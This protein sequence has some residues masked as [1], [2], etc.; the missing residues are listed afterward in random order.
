MTLIRGSVAICAIGLTVA[1]ADAAAQSKAGEVLFANPPLLAATRTVSRDGGVPEEVY[2][3]LRVEM[4]RGHLKNPAT[5]SDDQVLLR[6]YR[7]AGS[8]SRDRGDALV[9]PTIEAVPGQTVRLTLDNR[10]TMHA[11]EPFYEENVGSCYTGRGPGGPNDP[12]C[13]NGTNMHTHGL[14]ISPSG[15]SDNVLLNINP[16]VTFQYEYNIPPDHPSGTF[17][18]HPHLHG[19]TALQVGSGMVGAL[20]VR[21]DRAPTLTETGDLDTLLAGFG[22]SLLV[23]QQIPYA[24]F[25]AEGNI[26]TNQNGTWRCDPGQDGIVQDYAKQLGGQAWKGSGRYTSINGTVIPNFQ[27]EEPGSVQRWRMIHAGVRDTINVEFRRITGTRASIAGVAADQHGDWIDRNCGGAPLPFHLVASDGLTMQRA[28]PKTNAVMQPGYRWDALTVFPE[29]G[30]YCMI[31]AQTRASASINDAA[32][33]PQLLATVTVGPGAPVSGDLD[34]YLIA[35]L[36]AA[37][38][39][40]PAAVRDRV[41]RELDDG[42]KLTSFVPHRSLLADPAE[43]FGSQELMFDIGGNG[44]SVSNRIGVIGEPFVPGKVSRYLALTG[45][46]EWILT[47]NVAAHPFHIHVNPF[48]VVA[49]LDPDGNDLSQPGAVDPT[50]QDNQFAGM[51]GLWKDTLFV[52]QGTDPGPDKI[53]TKFYRAIVRTHYQRYIGKFVLH[54]HIL[55]HEDKGM[56]QEIEIVLPDGREGIVKS[57]HGHH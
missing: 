27:V 18:Y 46:D 36:K 34:R 40:Y 28:E 38:G 8:G 13:F 50:D 32:P 14:W 45:K 6:G 37:A 39:V 3:D 12:H 26:Q 21:G 43:E 48:Q 30:D 42:L 4:L 47:S 10:L 51:K 5:D 54:C 24:C 22:E 56:M 20:I 29:S 49:I 16:G 55:D 57:G 35:Q 11:G 31:D 53:S 25:D 2:F 19:S 1:T 9:A 33:S 23:M 17:W 41:R 15:N 7:K 52:K 44:F